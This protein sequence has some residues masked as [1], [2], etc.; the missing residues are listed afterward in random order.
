M[1]WKQN[2]LKR[3]FLRQKSQRCFLIARVLLFMTITIVE[4]KL[5]CKTKD[6]GSHSLGVGEQP[7][8]SVIEKRH[9]AE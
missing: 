6:R 2:L 3:H 9:E 8:K 1:T 5:P 7:L 4:I